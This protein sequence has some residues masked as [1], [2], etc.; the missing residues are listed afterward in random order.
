MQSIH[1]LEWL[2]RIECH[3][4][5][6]GFALSYSLNCPLFLYVFIGVDNKVG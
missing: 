3:E 2:L 4:I 6:Y 1:L 5:V